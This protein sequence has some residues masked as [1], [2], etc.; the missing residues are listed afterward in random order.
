MI[1]PYLPGVISSVP[2]FVQ[3]ATSPTIVMIR[4]VLQVVEELETM[5]DVPRSSTN[6]N[7]GQACILFVASCE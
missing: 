1:H 3:V 5:T 2:H 6:F 7:R 4:G